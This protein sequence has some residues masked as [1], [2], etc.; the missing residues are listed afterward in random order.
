MAVKHKTIVWLA[1]ATTLSAIAL[2]ALWAQDAAQPPAEQPAS[3]TLSYDFDSILSEKGLPF[4][5]L[6]AFATGVLVSFTPCVYPMIP[7]TI[8][9]VA[10]RDEKPSV[11]RSFALSCLYVL[12]LAVVYAALGVVVGT[13]GAAFRNVLMSTYVLVAVAVLF[14]ALALSMFGLYELQIPPSLA[15]RLQSVGGAGALGV[16]LMGMVSGIIASPCTAAPLAGILTF[17]AMSGDALKGFVLLFV[18]AWGMGLLLIVVGT[19]AGALKSLPKSGEWMVDF[20]YLFG[21]VFLGVALYF[22]RTLIPELV[23]YLGLSACVIAGGI[24][25]GALDSLPP[26]P[27][28]GLRIKRGIAV[29]IALLGSYMLIGTLWTHGLLLPSRPA[30]EAPPAGGSASLPEAAIEWQTD[31]QEAFRLASASEKPVLLDFRADW[32]PQC[33]EME[34]KAFPQPEIV[35]A[36]SRFVPLRVDVTDLSEE[37]EALVDRYDLP[38]YPTLVI[39]RGDGE[40]VDSFT[41]YEGPE[42]L[43]AFLQGHEAPSGD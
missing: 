31:I 39:A 43:L 27:G 12:G 34:K 41:G 8:G 20:K 13:V 17:V 1:M 10:G 15:T 3:P 7:I 35:D 21:F 36:V 30:A 28:A 19:S 23:Y 37:E 42:E 24:A 22:V 2:P 33:L 5:L 4:A 11:G 38:G 18:F 32:C 16:L 9:I 40:K 6:I 25:F 29:T 26:S 14:V